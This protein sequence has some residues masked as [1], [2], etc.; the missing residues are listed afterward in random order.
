L[1]RRVSD[2]AAV[3]KDLSEPE[4]GEV[5]CAPQ[6]TKVK[7]CHTCKEKRLRAAFSVS[8]SDLMTVQWQQSSRGGFVMLT[9]LWLVLGALVGA[10]VVL[11]RRNRRARNELTQALERQIYRLQRVAAMVK[12]DEAFREL[13]VMARGER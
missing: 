10:K 9:A 12:E 3:P 6:P 13:R 7:K 11:S 8:R 2:P 1:R 4:R 5:R